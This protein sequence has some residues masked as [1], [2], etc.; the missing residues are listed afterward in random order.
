VRFLP[1]VLVTTVVV[2]A[3]ATL[4]FH[5]RQ[6]LQTQ[7]VIV[8]CYLVISLLRCPASGIEVLKNQYTQCMIQVIGWMIYRDLRS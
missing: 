7:C 2:V 4:F 3:V 5:A 8:I 1:W 6:D